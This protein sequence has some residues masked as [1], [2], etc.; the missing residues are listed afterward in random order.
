MEAPI[1][2]S[3]SGFGGRG[4]PRPQRFIWLALHTTLLGINLAC[5]ADGGDDLGVARAA[6]DVAAEGGLD[7]RELGGWV[8]GEELGARHQHAG[9]AVA[10]LD[11]A[12]GDERGLERVEP[13]CRR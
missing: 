1:R 12:L 10:A 7:L 8:L 9:D 4:M 6:A 13:A 3:I 5:G 2:V 11:G